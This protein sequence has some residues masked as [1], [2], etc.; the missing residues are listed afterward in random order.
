MLSCCVVGLMYVDYS[1][2]HALNE[3]VEQVQRSEWQK[4]LLV[5]NL[6]LLSKYENASLENFCLEKD[7]Q[8]L[9]LRALVDNQPTLLISFSD[10]HCSSC[11]HS[12]FNV[13]NQYVSEIPEKRVIIIG[14]FQN[15]R[16]FSAFQTNQNI[17][18]P[19]CFVQEKDSN[20]SLLSEENLPFICLVDSSLKVQ[21]LHIP[22]KEIPKHTKRYMNMI[23]RRFFTASCDSTSSH[24][25]QRS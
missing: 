2:R 20:L 22:I 13:I 17:E 21:N 15:K 5:D 1:L 10:L 25:E 14:R 3:S 18:Y 23:I 19:V 6:M 16:S 7:G 4:D 8:K 11:I 9:Y 12:L 24:S